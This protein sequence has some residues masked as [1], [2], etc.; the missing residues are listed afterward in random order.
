VS[1]R[2]PSPVGRLHQ[3]Y[4]TFSN[5]DRESETSPPSDLPSAEAAQSIDGNRTS[6]LKIVVLWMLALP[7]LLGAL[8]V[9]LDLFR[10][11][12]MLLFNE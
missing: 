8:Y 10:Q 11:Q 2:A 1:S 3:D 5:T 7:L 12:I 9:C 6:N 4:N